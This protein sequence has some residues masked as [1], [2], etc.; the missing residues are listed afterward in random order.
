LPENIPPGARPALPVLDGVRVIVWPVLVLEEW[1]AARPMP[2]TAL[3]PPG[4]LPSVVPDIPNWSWHEYG[5]R[6]GFWRVR[7]LLTSLGVSPTVVVSSR[8][9]DTQPAVVESCVS[10]G[11]ELAAHGLEQIAMHA[12]PDERSIIERSIASIAAAAGTPPRGWFG[13]GLTETHQTLDLLADAGIEY[14]GDW[15]VDDEPVQLRCRRGSIVALPYNVELHDLAVMTLQHHSTDEFLRRIAAAFGC[16]HAEGATRP[17]VLAI[18]MHPFVS[19]TP[20][21]IGAV[22]AALERLVAHPDAVVWNGTH[23]LDWFQARVTQH[24]KRSFTFASR[25]APSLQP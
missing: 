25:P 7:S 14:V 12:V 22:M 6:A 10:A 5:M 24:G 18:A 15:L 2:R 19:G 16:L 17:R 13:P 3:P 23:I 8:L 21:R 20:H 4:N 9:C 11:W 1:D